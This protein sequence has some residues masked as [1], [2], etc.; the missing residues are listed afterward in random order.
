[1]SSPPNCNPSYDDDRHLPYHIRQYNQQELGN[2][3]DDS[4]SLSPPYRKASRNV[5]SKYDKNDI[6][7]TLIF[8]SSC[9]WMTIII[10]I[11]NTYML[12]KSELTEILKMPKKTINT[13]M[14]IFVYFGL[15]MVKFTIVF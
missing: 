10:V 6:V 1:M 13:T 9:S 8:C 7:S 14:T 15:R 3:N 4:E 2:T 5:M 11:F 12:L